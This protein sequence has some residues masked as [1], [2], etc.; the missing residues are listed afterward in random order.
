MSLQFAETPSKE[1]PARLMLTIGPTLHSSH[2]SILS[3]CAPPLRGP[4]G[5]S[6]STMAITIQITKDTHNY[7]VKDF[8]EQYTKSRSMTQKIAI[9]T[10]DNVT[11]N[12]QRL[13]IN[14]Q[15][16]AAVTQILGYKQS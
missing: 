4:S 11:D 2:R 16:V 12:W 15:A 7:I 1:F 14:S 10:N 5:K 3:E 6:I 13:Y 8:T 9:N